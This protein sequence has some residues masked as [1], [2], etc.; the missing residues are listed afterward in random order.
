MTI[1]LFA[2]SLLNAWFIGDLHTNYY[3]K[4]YLYDSLYSQIKRNLGKVSSHVET[5]PRFIV[6]A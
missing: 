5:D 1:V 6:F 3:S 4:I 2:E